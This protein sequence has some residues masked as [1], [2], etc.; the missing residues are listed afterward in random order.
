MLPVQAG[1]GRQL[2][3]Q[4]VYAE[5]GGILSHQRVP[6]AQGGGDPLAIKFTY[7]ERSIG[8]EGG[9]RIGV[10]AEQIIFVKKNNSELIMHLQ[11]PVFQIWIQDPGSG[12]FLTPGSGM[13]NRVVHPGSGMN[14]T[15]HELRNKFLG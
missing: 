5:G 11:F 8:R 4:L 2:A 6:A 15:D 7:K 14:N 13:G 3:G 12:A 1:P 9:V 10:S